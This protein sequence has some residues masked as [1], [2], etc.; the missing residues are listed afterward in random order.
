MIITKLLKKPRTT[1]HEN[2]GKEGDDGEEGDVDA[3]QD[4]IARDGTE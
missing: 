3:E 4:L 1:F 2:V